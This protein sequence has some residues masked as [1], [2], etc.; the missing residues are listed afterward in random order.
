MELRRIRSFV[1]VADCQSF[2]RA[3]GRLAIAQSALSRQIRD[4]ETELGAVL[5][6]RTGR[7]V[8][9]TDAG[10]TFLERGRKLLSD[11]E[12][13]VAETKLMENGGGTVHLGVPPSVSQILLAPLINRLRQERPQLRL[14]IVEGFSGHISE[15][16]L[17]GRIDLAILY[18]SSA[19]ANLLADM[20]V[21]ED[22]HLV[23]PPASDI[24]QRRSV[25][26]A[27]VAALPLAL[28]SRPHGL[29]LLV[30]KM[31]EKAGIALELDVEVDAFSTMKELAQTGMAYTILPVS[32]VAQEI[33][34]GRLAAARIVD[35]VVSRELVFVSSGQ[36]LHTRAA[37]DV[38]RIVR[39]QVAELVASGRWQ[40]RVNG[41]SRP[42][43]AGV[44]LTHTGIQAGAA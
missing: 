2:T 19:T 3:G 4:L 14:R 22:L 31:C 30:D 6:H 10:R 27:E 24:V 28:P 26:L 9:L 7:G 18:R 34:Q 15:W 40:A 32:A 21:S 5:L 42:R 29:R 41:P 16:L 39:Q 44:A 8:Q 20:L 43:Q 17:A 36:R 35:P 12:L 33:E 23:G 38:S 11:A 37:K 1:E 25:R 13:L